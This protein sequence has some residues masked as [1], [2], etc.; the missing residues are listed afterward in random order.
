MK[1][2]ASRRWSAWRLACRASSVHSGL[3]QRGPAR[4]CDQARRGRHAGGRGGTQE[5]PAE[6]RDLEGG[7]REG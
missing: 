6:A 3:S 4:A 7:H 1:S 5:P 2:Q